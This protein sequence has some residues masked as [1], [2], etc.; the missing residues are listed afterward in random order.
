MTGL[1]QVASAGLLLG[2]IYALMAGGL[3]L[4]FGVF[5]V[6]NIAHGELMFGG[7]FVSWFM[8]NGLGVHP[9]LTVPF[10]A[11][12]M[13]IVGVL[14]QV[15]LV[16]RALNE[17]PV[18]SLLML[19]GVSLVA[20]GI[21]IRL[22]SVNPRVIA[23]F[24]GSFEVAGVFIAKSRLAA[25]LVAV[26]VLLLVHLYLKYSKLGI[27]TKATAQNADIAEACGIDVGRVRYITMGLAAALAGVAG[28]LTIMILPFTPQSG[29]QFGVIAFVVAVV[30]GLGSFYGAILAGVFL[31]VGQNLLAWKTDQLLSDALIFVF[32][33]GV[34]ALRPAGIISMTRSAPR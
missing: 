29:F 31:G 28:A 19:F 22:F 8:W 23:Y 5:G 34:L 2:L 30:G 11:L 18:V 21:G 20:Q 1:V 24:S 26:P 9:L 4:I 10:A 14:L 3:S 33:V 13:F 15:V 12:A 27:A 25:A 6:L 32:L 7:A 17:S 16:E